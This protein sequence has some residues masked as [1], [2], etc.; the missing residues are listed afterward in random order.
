MALR[1]TRQYGEVAADGAGELR[2]TRQY[3][4][5]LAAGDGKIRVTRQYIEVLALTSVSHEENAADVISFTQNVSTAGTQLGKSLSDTLSLSHNAVA[6]KSGIFTE[7]V[8]DTLNFTS[9]ASRVIPASASNTMS[10]TQAIIDNLILQDF[11]PLSSTISFTQQVDVGGHNYWLSHDLGLTD[12]LDW[13]GPKY[14]YVTTYL[15]I[16]SQEATSS[17]GTPWLPI[18]V[19]HTLS[20]AEVVNLAYPYSLNNV[21]TLTHEAYRSQT[22][23]D[24]LGLVQTVE[25]GKGHTIPPEDM[26]ID[27]TVILNATFLRS[28][29]SDTAIGHALTYYID[30]ACGKKQY[31]PFI[32]ENTISNAPSPPSNDLPVVQNDP[33]TTRF[34]LSY[35]ALASPTATVELRAPE[36]DNIDRVAFN[37][38]SRETRGGK[39]TI[40]A[41]PTWPQ[42]QTVIVT[43]VGLLKTE[44]DDLHAFFV[45]YVGEEIGM[46][47]WEGR[48]WVGIVTTPNEAA[49]HDGKGNWTITFEF[50]GVLVDG[51]IPSTAMNITDVLGIDV[52]YNRGFTDEIEFIQSA[53]YIKA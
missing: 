53:D 37:R 7:N 34:R 36:L 43:F 52:D 8:V 11:F 17:K 23:T 48:E 47:D 39:L 9:V 25:N 28:V 13:L 15:S 18:E 26:G 40:F 5:V 29:D 1:V 20:L 33:A 31:A 19:E 27:H 2:V 21:M 16:L 10:L 14:H 4:E 51:Y 38:I 24:A 3:G 35:P 49:V 32:G 50:E 45:T 44:V 12:Q 41:D 6:A 22:P 46:S 30:S 42:V